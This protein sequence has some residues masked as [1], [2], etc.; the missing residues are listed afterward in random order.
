MRCAAATGRTLVLA[1]PLLKGSV[2]PSLPAWPIS[3]KCCEN[4]G[5]DPN[6]DLFLSWVLV[7]S[8]GFSQRADC[9]RDSSTRR[10]NPV[11]P[12]DSV[13]RRRWRSCRF[14][15]SDFLRAKDFQNSLGFVS[16]LHSGTKLDERRLAA[17]STPER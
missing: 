3:A 8:T 13:G 10:D 12:I 11:A 5:V 16:G 14:C 2:H 1:E 17:P 4:L 15:G 9:C 6:S 7:L